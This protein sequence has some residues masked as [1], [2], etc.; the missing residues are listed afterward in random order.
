MN[1]TGPEKKRKKP[2]YVK[3]KSMALLRKLG[4]VV[5]DVERRQTIP[6]LGPITFDLW[7]FADMIAIKRPSDGAASMV[8]PF[9]FVNATDHTHVAHRIK[10][11]IA[12]PPLLDVLRGGHQAEVH[13]WARPTKVK[14]KTWRLRRVALRAVKETDGT[15][16]I[17]ASEKHEEDF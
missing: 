15:W 12:S 14:R 8:L 13:G 3:H 11:G 4:Y 7:G 16:T 17:I 1:Q 5:G 2:V 10:K 9:L 6:G